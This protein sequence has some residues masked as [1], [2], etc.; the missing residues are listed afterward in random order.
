M[1]LRHSNGKGPGAL[2][3]AAYVGPSMNPTLRAPEIME[4]VPYGER[5]VRV[6]DVVFF[7]PPGSDQPVVHRA[8]RAT[9]AGIST[10]GD[11]NAQADAYLVPRERIQGQV[12]AARRGQQRRPIAGGAKGRWIRR[13]LG[14]RRALDHGASPLLHPVYQAL[15]RRGWIARWLP[16]ALRPRVVVFHCHGRDQRQ[17]LL[18]KR[19]V[20][21]YSDQQHQWQIQRP[22][23]LLVDGRALPRRQDRERM[24]RKEL[25]ERRRTLGDL[26]AQ[27]MPHELALADGTR[28]R[29]AAG[30]EAAAAIVSQLGGAMQ[31]SRPGAAAGSPG[32]HPCRL[33]V[34]VEEHS[35]VAECYAPLASGNGGDVVCILSPSE[36]W[37]GPFHN[38]VRLSLVFAREAQARGGVLIHGALAEKDGRGVILAAAGGTGKTTASRRLPAPWRSLCDD[39]ALVVR[40]SQGRYWAH[41]WP[42]WSRFMD[43]GPGGAWDVQNAVPLQG[44]FVLAQSRED[45]AERVGPG[46]AVSLLMEGVKQA[47]QYMPLGLFSDEIGALYLEGFDNLCALARAI[48]THVLHLSMTG[49]FWQEIDRILEGGRG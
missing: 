36:H 45:R 38:L 21:R 32:E 4:I 9:S 30:D 6:G 13:W 44:L 18:G 41:P 46:H 40:D 5:P 24:N 28:W 33:L 23:H 34:Q 1:P 8:I 42:T 7:L 26:L 37:G 31:W 10:R 39:T 11:N 14:W 25:A 49:A 12:V 35:T 16:A 27:G 43:G 17:L 15:H 2:F 22:F 3:F 19:V 20:G 29:I 47:S 48:P